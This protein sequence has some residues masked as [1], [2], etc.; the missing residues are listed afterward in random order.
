MYH[1]SEQYWTHQ[2]AEQVRS[3][4]STDE[5]AEEALRIGDFIADSI[6]GQRSEGDSAR[7]APSIKAK[8]LANPAVVNENRRYQ[9]IS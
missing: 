2:K 1:E 3:E 5:D 6:R 8:L 9:T 7:K 4:H